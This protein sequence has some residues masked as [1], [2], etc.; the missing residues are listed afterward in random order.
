MECL[1]S[2]IL[3]VSAVQLSVFQDRLALAISDVDKKEVLQ[4]TESLEARL[5]SVCCEEEKNALIKLFYK[6]ISTVCTNTFNL[7]INPLIMGALFVKVLPCESE[8]ITKSEEEGGE[9]CGVEKTDPF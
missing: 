5:A 8:R 3:K 1:A 4:L 2:R 7:R 6:Q 9:P